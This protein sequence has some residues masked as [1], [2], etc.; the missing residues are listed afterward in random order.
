MRIVVAEDNPMGLEL[1]CE[2]LELDGHTVHAAGDGAEAVEMARRL[3]PDVVLMDVHLPRLDGIEATRRLQE[4]PATRSIPVIA[5]SASVTSIEF[6]RARE[7]GCVGH[8][9]KPL[10]IRKLSDEISRL[11]QSDWMEQVA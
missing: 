2:V 9:T 7:A 5:L 4:D 11:P 8:L 3:R 10:D 6:Q 1:L